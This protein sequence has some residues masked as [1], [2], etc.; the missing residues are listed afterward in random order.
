MT[1][2]D[3]GRNKHLSPSVGKRERRGAK[4]ARCFFSVS[5]SKWA[6]REQ[7]AFFHR[8]TDYFRPFFLS[9]SLL[10][11]LHPP[12][13]TPTTSWPS[14]D[15]LMYNSRCDLHPGNYLDRMEGQLVNQNTLKLRQLRPAGGLQV[16]RLKLLLVWSWLCGVLMEKVSAECLPSH[17]Y[18]VLKNFP[19]SIKRKHLGN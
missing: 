15:I 16:S 10:P 7:W 5:K 2:N 11:S 18:C 1:F 19:R 17:K 3:L 4:K 13:V 9:P 6:P 8:D 14:L 12:L